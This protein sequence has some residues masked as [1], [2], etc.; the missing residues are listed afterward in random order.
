MTDSAN[1]AIS[2]VLK[3][4]KQRLLILR[5]L[6]VGTRD[7]IWL[8]IKNWIKILIGREPYYDWRGLF[9]RQYLL[10]LT[11][12]RPIRKITC[13][14]YRTE[15][16]GS[17]AIVIM[18]AI[19]F[20]RCAGLTYVHTPFTLI[21]HADR[22]MEQ[23]AAAWETLFNFGAGEPVCEIRRREAVSYCHNFPEL[24][25]CLGWSHDSEVLRRSFNTLIP[26][27]RRKYYLNKT[28]RARRRK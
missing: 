20:A 22:P 19:N 9:V 24:E 8:G 15:G 26:E 21:E 12:I 18:N 7:C 10:H 4:P 14:G 5:F 2:P 25:L 27:F 13:I 28:P 17:Q 23:W 1:A 6:V 3:R 16:P 11:G